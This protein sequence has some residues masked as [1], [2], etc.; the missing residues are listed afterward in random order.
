MD[1]VKNMMFYGSL[2]QT[3]RATFTRFVWSE[4]WFLKK[5]KCLSLLDR[6]SKEVEIRKDLKISHLDCM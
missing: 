2:Q 6:L 1:I 5:E 4:I 3:M